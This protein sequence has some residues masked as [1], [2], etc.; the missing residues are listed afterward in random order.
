VTHPIA[1][2]SKSPR[3]KCRGPK[4]QSRVQQNA[5]HT[6]TVSTLTS[7]H[8]ARLDSWIWLHS[9]TDSPRKNAIESLQKQI[10]LH[11][12][13]ANRLKY[14]QNSHAAI[15][16]LPTELFEEVFLRI[17]ESSLQDGGAHFATGTFAFLQVCR[18]WNEVAVG[19]PQLW[20]WWVAGAFKAWPLFNSRSND[21]PLF[22][23]W[24]SHLPA[25][26]R[27]V[28]MDPTIPERIRNLDFSGTSTQLAHFLSVFDSSPPS[29]ASSIRFQISIPYDLYQPQR[30]LA[31]F[32]SS[33]FPKL[34]QLNLGNFQL[35]PS[36]PISTTSRL[37]SLKLFLPYEKENHYTLSQFSQTLQ[38]LPNLR[39][40]DLGRSA[41]PLPGSLGTPLVPLFLPRLVNLRLYGTDAAILGFI[42]LIDMSS[43]LYNVVLRFS[44]IPASSSWDL[45][46]IAKK[47]LTGYYECQ[48]LNPPRKVNHLTISY[49]PKNRHLAFSTRSHSAPKSNLRLQF[50]MLDVLGWYNM[51]G[52]TFP[53]FPLSDLREFAAEGLVDFEDQYRTMF[54][55]MKDLSHLRLDRLD[56]KEVLGAL[57]LGD[58][59]AFKGSYQN[60]VDLPTGV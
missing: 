2:T 19:F 56:A 18:R 21:T 13:E 60:H 39:E 8:H 55:K 7:T 24:R 44:R 31:R 28:L 4:A 33:P 51:V 27:D 49:N 36:H 48:G 6:G 1:P 52:R 59:G 37:N 35:S 38:Q 23:T 41:I 5:Q 15:S 58:R 40:L 43:P 32:L 29:N 45:A 12:G 26:A 25:S 50:N 11:V 57:S 10:D 47:I 22:L 42:D 3:L 9:P 30:D 34:S 53:L 54:E 20:G 16:R 46:N 14:A 17:V